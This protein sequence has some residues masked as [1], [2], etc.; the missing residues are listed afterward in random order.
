MA[1]FL[2][3]RDMDEHVAA[4]AVRLDE[5]IA[6]YWIK[7]LHR[8][9]RHVSISSEKMW[10]NE[11]DSAVEL[12]AARWQKAV[13]ERIQRP[14]LALVVNRPLPPQPSGMA[15]QRYLITAKP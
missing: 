6:L 11:R 10:S 1:R 7:P 2:D 8:P 12:A 14:P 9:H 5:S 13:A 3:R 15:R 4:A